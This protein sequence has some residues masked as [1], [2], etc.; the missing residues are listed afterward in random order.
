MKDLT[1]A[2]VLEQEREQLRLR[3]QKMGLAD[4]PVGHENWFGLA[5]SGGGIRSATINMGFLRTL[6][7]YG[8]LRQADYLSTVS[9]G[10]YTHSYVQ[11]TL[12]ANGGDYDQLFTTDQIDSLRQH[13]EY[14]IPGQGIWQS[15]NRLVL[16]VAFLVSWLMS[17]VSLLIVAGIAYFLYLSAIGM[18]LANPIPALDDAT[19]STIWSHCLPAVGA[20]LGAHFLANILLNFNLSISKTFNYIEVAVALLV[21]G[22]LV[23]V[24][25]S[26]IELDRQVPRDEVPHYALYTL[27]LFL[28]GFLTNPN[29]LSFHR[30]YRKQLADLFLRFAGS[31]QNT[32]LKDVFDAKSND[33]KQ[34]VAPYPLINTCLNLQAPE[35]DARFK[36]LKASD[37]FVLSPLFC[38]AKLTNY[39]RTADVRDYRQM[40]LPAAVTV[41]AAAVNPGMGIYSNR[42]LSVLMTLLNARLGFWITNPL[43]AARR[44]GLVWWPTYFFKELLGRIGTSNRMVN[45]SDGGHIENLAVYEL[46]RRECR[47]IVAVDAGEDPQYLFFDL[48]NLNIRAR[49]ELGYEIRFRPGQY[50]EDLIRPRPTQVYSTQRFVVADIYQHWVDEKTLDPTTGELVSNIKNFDEPRKTGTFVYVKSSVVAP[51]GKPDLSP[52]DHLR[53]GTYKYKIYHADFPHETTS[54]QFFDEIQWE[55]YYQLGQFIGA[56]VLGLKKP[57]AE[58]GHVTPRQLVDWFDHGVSPFVR[59]PEGDFESTRPASRTPTAPPTEPEYQM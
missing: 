49:N 1:L 44:R 48:Q 56:E 55:A 6:N 31:Y 34:Y 2:D 43:H 10:G 24:G 21:V 39:V 33:P 28:A 14:L 26:G 41:S 18:G 45:I 29:A 38:G 27:L 47:L 23:W 15:G 25:L 37:Y 16:I 54:D 32:P 57:D 52:Q 35:G 36:G 59:M 19:R 22:F 12:K 3:R 46:L 58:T 4:E 7:R 13:G 51:V 11:G 9:G 50:P 17:L 5:L 40:T 8:I 42:L 30:F 20:L 53:Y